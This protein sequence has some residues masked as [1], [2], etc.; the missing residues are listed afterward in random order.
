M[1]WGFAHEFNNLERNGDLPIMLRTWN[2]RGDLP[3]SLRTRNG[4][5]PTSSCNSKWKRELAYKF[6]NSEWNG[7]FLI[8]KF[9]IIFLLAAQILNS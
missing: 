8:N 6:F 9:P 7:N 2:G 3:M 5:L 4:N 1:E